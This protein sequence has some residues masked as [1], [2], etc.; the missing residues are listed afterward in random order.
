MHIRIPSLRDTGQ[1][2]LFTLTN[3]SLVRL[4]VAAK[5]YIEAFIFFFCFSFPFRIAF[6]SCSGQWDASALFLSPVGIFWAA[7]IY[8]EL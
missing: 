5:L 8:L 4:P 1:Q 6:F 7:D 3:R 2:G